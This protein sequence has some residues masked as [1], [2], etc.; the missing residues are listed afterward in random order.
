MNRRKDLAPWVPVIFYQAGG[1][2]VHFR[3]EIM[4]YLSLILAL[5]AIPF[6]LHR[7]RRRE[8]SDL[9][10]GIIAYLL[11]AVV[12]Y[13]LLPPLGGV[14]SRFPFTLFFGV[15]FVVT[16]VPPLWGREPFTCFFA[17]QRTSEAVWQTDLFKEINFH[18]TY[19]WAGLFAVSGVLTMLPEMTTA[20]RTQEMKVVFAYILPWI[21]IFGAGFPVTAWYP[22]HRQRRMGLTP[23]VAGSS[24]SLPANPPPSPPGPW[25]EIDKPE[26]E[27]HITPKII[28]KD[29]PEMTDTYRIVAVNGSPHEGFG[30]TSQMLAMLREPLAAEGFE[31]EEIFLSSLHIEYCVG[32]ATCLEKG[33]CWI[34]DDYKGLAKKLLEAEA[35]ILASPVYFRH[36]TAQLKTFLD[37]SLG[38][39]HRPRGAWKPGLA[40]S[41]SA[42]WGET[43]VARYLALT[44][45]VFG[46]FAVGQLTAIAIGPGHFL[47]KELV[48]ARAGEMAQDLARAV[49]EKRRFPATD[50]D[51]DYWRF[52]GG[53]VRENRDFMKADYEHW[54][55]LGILD[56]FEAYVGQ[57]WETPVRDPAMR[58]A[59]LKGLM[60]GQRQKSGQGEP[61]SAPPPSSGPRQFANLRELLEAMPQALNREA[62]QGLSATYQFQ[63]SGTENFVAH[64][65]I[66]GQRA[67]FQEGPAPKPDVIIK[68]PADVWLAISKGELDGAQAFM[69]GRYQVEGDLGLLLKLKEL[70]S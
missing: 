4:R 63:V 2:M 24:Q 29:H 62:A 70:F 51:L 30:N 19:F 21:L 16:S 5:V 43:E 22:G 9:E 14:M 23:V 61:P 6:I 34:R 44:L 52:M 20:M 64:V 67:T 11:L 69:T 26:L 48:A 41:V 3:P 31:L 56:S 33:A 50:Q 35:V 60:E 27:P 12:G 58:E 46:A 32:C 28:R 68:T 45:R 40:V 55:N 59:W 65:R 15:Q 39:G 13:W 66:E 17:R 36:V 18:L 10:I 54:Q 42:G 1:G 38:L 7:F 57:T 49:K 37:R 53:L 25:A 8:A 47:G